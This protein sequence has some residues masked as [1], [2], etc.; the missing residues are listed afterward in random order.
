[1]TNIFAMKNKQK[2]FDLTEKQ[3]NSAI[4]LIEKL[5]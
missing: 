5:G 3:I 1:M 2:S 4:G